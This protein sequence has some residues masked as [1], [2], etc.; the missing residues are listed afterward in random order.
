MTKNDQDAGWRHQSIPS[1]W[2][3]SVDD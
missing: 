1:R 3:E 2:I